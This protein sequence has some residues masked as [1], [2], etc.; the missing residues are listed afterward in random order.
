MAGR[1]KHRGFTIVE[2]LVVIAITGLLVSLLLPAVQSARAAANRIQC[3]NNLHQIGL[4]LHH[5]HNSLG[6]F[7]PGRGTPTPLIFSPQ[8]FLLPYLE[9]QNLQTKI[10][11]TAPPANFTVPPATVYDGSLN[12]P[13]AESMV[14]NYLCPADGAAGRIAGSTFGCTNYVG[15]TGSGKVDGG[16]LATTD[17]VFLMGV[18]HA[19]RDITD[20]LS[21]TIAFS[22]RTLGVGQ[23]QSSTA[24]SDAT[25]AMREFPGAATPATSLC[26]ALSSG[27]WNHERGAKWIV[28]N[29]GNTLYNHAYPPNDVNWDC[30]NATQQRALMTARSNH[31]GGV[32]T[33]RCDGSVQ[34]V[35]N[36]IALPIWQALATRAEGEILEN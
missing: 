1:K 6:K 36:T 27:S 19:E 12:K 7:P 29:Y 9:Q 30:L 28:G 5:H 15:T 32:A 35:A 20:G 31:P 13:A 14:R 8:A 33:L 26:D 25:R 4:A 2:L 21:Q 17:G 34:F 11:I 16:N 24:M 18:A 23:T 10:D 22:E 3:A